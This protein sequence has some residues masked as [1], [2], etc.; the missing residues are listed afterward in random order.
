MNFEDQK[1]DL[2]INSFILNVISF[3]ITITVIFF[4]KNRIKIN[5]GYSNFFTTK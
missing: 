5:F 1:T 4:I 2:F 3:N